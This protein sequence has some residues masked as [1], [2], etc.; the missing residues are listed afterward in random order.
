MPGNATSGLYGIYVF[1]FFKKQPNF[2]RLAILFYIP[3]SRKS[4]PVSLH[5]YQNLAL[6]LS[7]YFNHSDRREMISPVVVICIFLLANDE[8]L[9]MRLL[10]ICLSSSMKCLFTFFAHFKIFRFLS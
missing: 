10:D 6:L 8:H 3:T 1:S 4:D 2:S 5:P 9:F 7:V